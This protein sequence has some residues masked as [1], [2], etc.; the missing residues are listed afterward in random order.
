MTTLDTLRQRL[1]SKYLEPVT[2]VT[3]SVP[4]TGNITDTA[5][6]LTILT[7]VLSAD[8]ESLI[9][10][11]SFFE[12]AAEIVQCTAY[13]ESTRTL[14]IRRHM[15]GTTAAAHVAASALRAPRVETAGTANNAVTFTTRMVTAKYQ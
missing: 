14:T 13:D 15:R 1:E 7:N 10:P 11:G 5:T 2:E 6:E 4:I 8:E 3:P 12:L 9:G